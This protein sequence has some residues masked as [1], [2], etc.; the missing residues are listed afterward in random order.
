VILTLTEALR[1]EIA[2]PAYPRAASFGFCVALVANDV[3]VV[4]LAVSEW[5]DVVESRASSRMADLRE[6][7][8]WCAWRGIRGPGAGGRSH[9]RGMGVAGRAATSPASGPSISNIV[10]ADVAV[11][12]TGM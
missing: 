2:T 1:C 5:R 10:V 9:D 4:A 6:V 8:G 12:A 11:P 7:A 3:V